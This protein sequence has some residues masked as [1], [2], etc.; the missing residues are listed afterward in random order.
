LTG[1]HNA[2]SMLVKPIRRIIGERG[3]MGPTGPQIAA[4]PPI[5]EGVNVLL[6]APTGTGKTE[7]AF[8]PVFSRL[9]ESVERRP[10]VK[11]LYITPL[12]SLN[13]DIL[14]RLQWWCGKLDIKVAVRHGD[15]ST[16]ERLVQSRSPPDMLITTPETLQAILPGRIFRRHLRSIRWVIVDE[17]HE[18]AEDKRG[19]QLSLALERLRV[20][21]E[22]DFQLIGL[23]ATIGSPE[24]VGKFLVGTEREVEIV[25]APVARYMKFQ[26]VCPQPSQEDYSL[27]TSLYTHPEVA[28][29]LRVMRRLI[30]GHR[31]VLLF[32]NTRSIA[33][34]LAS[35]FKIWDVDFPVSIHHG[36]LAKPARITAEKGLKGGDLRGLVCTSSLELGIDVGRIDLC[37]QYMSP[38][39]VTRLVQRVGRSGH[40]IDRVAKGIIITMDSDD[41][42]EAMV[43]ARRACLED[44]EPVAIP[45]RPLDALTHQIVGLFTMWRRWGFNQILELF[46]KAYP[47]RELD[48]NELASVLNYMHTRP[49]RLAFVL[50]EDKVAMRPMNAK[51][52]YKYYYETLS[53]IPDVKNY[54]IVD[55]TSEV[56]VG[57]LDEAFVAEYGD[58]GTKFIV[59]GSAW[60]IS[61]VYG[62]KIYVK[63]VDDPTG[64]IPSWVGEEIPVPYEVANE[65]GEIRSFVEERLRQ[66]DPPLSIAESL[67]KK[68]PADK[69]TIQRAISETV[70]QV[71][72]GFKVPTDRRLVIEDW[73]DYTIIHVCLGSLGNRTLTVLLGHILSEETGY[74]IGIQGDPYRV[75]IQ[76]AEVV[77][78][79]MVREALYELSTI[80]IKEI[81]TEAFVK[82]GLFK[83]RIINVARK[84]GAVAKGADFSNISLMQLTKSFQGTAIFDEAV[85]ET[86]SK[87]TDLQNL[88]L[89]IEGIRRGDVEITL[90]EKGEEATPLT[91]IGL[92]NV[93]R[94]RSIISSEKMKRLT[95][96]SA[97]ARLFNEVMT[98][99]C[100]N[101]WGFIQM[102]PIK[103]LEEEVTCPRCGSNRI[104]VLRKSESDVRKVSEKRGGR[105]TGEE[106]K[107]EEKAIKTASLTAKYGKLAAVVLAGKNLRLS[108][109]EDI[110]EK[111]EGINDN[112]FEL[113]VE[114]ERM[115]L[116]RRFW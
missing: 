115:A 2:F 61:S 107:M 7:A 97:R 113:I 98:F 116:K 40:R 57:I 85:K 100:T 21:A 26:I 88:S 111:A 3:F 49:P 62:D 39:Q 41:T 67:S 110:L 24:K 16:K 91:R 12:R 29:R 38:R 43:I 51:E 42:L 52:M 94:R 71:R 65:V 33:E 5:L 9:I 66:G 31:A 53:M 83:R 75:I 64:A 17:V 56:P 48:E 112:L 69:D 30:E 15:T 50:S 103:N 114:A 55:E 93:G 10:G 74:P 6:I 77:N 105:L 27:A 104:G 36:S 46:R 99:V 81:V 13:R 11:V 35:R 63:P 45:D 72:L 95:I 28:A 73:E 19:S 90:I 78:S 106:S 58:P 82:T 25:K 37:L 79:K 8:L 70:E 108:K 96:E 1:V 86:L 87:D 32:T 34:V 14:K 60:R 54:L 76:N 18:F 44:L 47:Y 22:R 59:R 23:S 109:A 92:E 80:V 102:I 4:I 89:F 101:C 84:F 20:I 68:Y